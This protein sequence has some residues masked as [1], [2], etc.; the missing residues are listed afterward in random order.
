MPF[1]V[2]LDPIQLGGQYAAEDACVGRIDGHVVAVLLRVGGADVP[3]DAQ[4]W[5]L[6]IGFGPCRGEGLMFPT[7]EAAARWMTGKAAE[8]WL[9]RESRS[10]EMAAK[11]R[12]VGALV[13]K[14]QS[15]ADA[16][17]STAV[18]EGDRN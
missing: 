17:R 9:A 6:E 18:A 5:F 13:S 12:R 8:S 3:R 7:L 11:L 4:G 2:L 15:V 14:G 10:D 16:I 1:E